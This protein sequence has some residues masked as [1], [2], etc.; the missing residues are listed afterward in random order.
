MVEYTLKNIDCL[1]L[2]S[3]IEANSIDHINCDPPY[4]IGYDGGDDWDTFSSDDEYLEWSRKWIQECTRV[5]KPNRMMCVWGT[6]KNRFVLSS[7]A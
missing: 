6:Q 5:L 3:S 4:N 7:E 1:D 2:L